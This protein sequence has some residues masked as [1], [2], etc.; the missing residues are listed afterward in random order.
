[1]T[2]MAKQRGLLPIAM[3][4]GWIAQD[5]RADRLSLVN[6]TQNRPARRSPR[7]GFFALP[8]KQSG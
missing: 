3:L 4:T 6:A 7:A 8:L 2:F 5:G 1:L